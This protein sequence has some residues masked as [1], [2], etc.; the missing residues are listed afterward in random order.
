MQADTEIRSVSTFTA[1]QREPFVPV[2]SLLLQQ[3]ALLTKL[4][5]TNPTKQRLGSGAFGVAYETELP[6][7]SKSVLKLTRD[8]TEVQASVLLQGKACSR[9][10]K[11]Y[12]VWAVDGTHREGLR[13][14][15]LIHREYLHPLRKPDMVLVDAIFNLLGDDILDLTIPR[16]QHRAMLDKWRDLLRDELYGAAVHDEGAIQIGRGGQQLHRA[17]DLLTKIGEAVAEMHR[18]GIDW[19]DVHSGNIMR[20]DAGKIVIGDVG[21]GLVHDDF[22]QVV[23]YLTDEVAVAYMQSAKTATS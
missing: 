11:I 4:G 5:L 16:R 1:L 23:P 3:R 20:N 22:S 13:G 6:P 10:V 12:G 8:P 7:W 2:G 19:E 15:Y 21:W 17:V 14:W 18:H 9:I